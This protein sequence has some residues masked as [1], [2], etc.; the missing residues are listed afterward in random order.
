V[1]GRHPDLDGQGRR[2]RTIL[3]TA[4]AGTLGGSALLLRWVIAGF[5]AAVA[6]VLL[7]T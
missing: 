3:P 7:L 5:A 6:V 4:V 1:R 2:I